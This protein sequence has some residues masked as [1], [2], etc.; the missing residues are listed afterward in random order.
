LSQHPSPAG[1]VRARLCFRWVF[2]YPA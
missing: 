1:F 2:W